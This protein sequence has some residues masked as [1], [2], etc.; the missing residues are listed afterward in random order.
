MSSGKKFRRP[1]PLPLTLPPNEE[2]W[3]NNPVAL[4][5]GDLMGPPQIPPLSQHSKFSLP[6]LKGN[7]GS[8]QKNV[9]HNWG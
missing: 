4:Q 1:P 7:T 9:K 2:E 8:S 6:P 3:R 5:P